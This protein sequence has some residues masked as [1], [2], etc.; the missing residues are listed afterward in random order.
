MTF[1]AEAAE[2]TEERWWGEPGCIMAEQT[3]AIQS[4]RRQKE[5][6]KE[7]DIKIDIV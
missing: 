1:G 4:G 3:K 2:R 6:E 7:R 5:R